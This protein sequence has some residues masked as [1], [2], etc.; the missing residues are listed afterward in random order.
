VHHDIWDSDIPSAPGLVD[1]VQNGRTIPAL[2]SVGK[3]GYMF[4]LDRTSGKPVFGVEE[5]RVPKGDVPGEWY[6]PT[7]PFPLKPPPLAKTSF[8]KEDMVT[9]SDTTPEHAKACQE[10]WD[11][12]GGFTNDGPFTPFRFHGD[13]APPRSTIQFPGGTGGINWGGTATDP[14]TGYVYLNSHDTSLVGWVEKRKPGVEYSFDTRGSDAPYDRAAYDGPGPFHTFSAPL[15]DTK[16]SGGR[17]INLPCQRPPWARLI[18]VNA[19]TGDIA[20]QITLG[21]TEELPEGRRNTGRSGSAGPTVTAGG[22]VF[23]GAADDRRFRAFDSKTG[24]ELWSAK[25]DGAGNANPIVYQG[26]NGKQYVAIVAASSVVVFAL[27]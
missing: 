16:N 10:V 24:T 2:T 22:L 26:R 4:I 3:T 13:G 9:A 23:I 18:A 20:W 21:T 7:Q 14:R 6:A 8:K 1:I 12:S 11:K 25:L 5:R 19:N 17:P 15:Q 27:P